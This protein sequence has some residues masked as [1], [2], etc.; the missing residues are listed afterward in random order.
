MSGRALL[1]DV[2]RI[3]AEHYNLLMIKS[4]SWLISAWKPKLSEAILIGVTDRGRAKLYLEEEAVITK[5]SE[6][7]KKLERGTLFM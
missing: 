5:A 7:K 3:N 6:E 4:K 1:R 2:Y